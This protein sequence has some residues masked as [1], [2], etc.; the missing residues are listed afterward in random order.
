MLMK[1][2]PPDLVAA[3]MTGLLVSDPV[4]M[5]SDTSTHITRHPSD[6][7]I[8]DIHAFSGVG[9]DGVVILLNVTIS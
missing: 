3:N 7:I 1:P 8:H 4:A 2:H 6:A 9:I 5:V